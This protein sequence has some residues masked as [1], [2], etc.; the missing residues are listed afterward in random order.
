MEKET[1]HH[2]SGFM[3]CKEC[4]GLLKKE[5]GFNLNIYY[6]EKCKKPCVATKPT[7]YKNCVCGNK[8]L[9]KF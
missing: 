4:L 1:K 3:N 2:K 6:C 8:D 9:F 5:E 7:E